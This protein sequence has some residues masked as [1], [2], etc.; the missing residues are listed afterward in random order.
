MVRL[1][2]PEPAPVKGQCSTW[3]R[4]WYQAAR[5]CSA[6]DT[7]F[8]KLSSGK[9]RTRPSPSTGIYRFVPTYLWEAVTGVEALG[10]RAD[11]DP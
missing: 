4:H 5:A 10:R 7:M 8:D 2:L 6:T 11:I 9:D 3:R 1:A